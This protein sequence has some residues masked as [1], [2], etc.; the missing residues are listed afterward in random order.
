[1]SSG[2][3]RPTRVIAFAYKHG[4]SLH[5]KRTLAHFLKRTLAHFLKRAFVHFLERAFVLAFEFA[6]TLKLIPFFFFDSNLGLKLLLVLKLMLAFL[7]L[8]VALKRTTPTR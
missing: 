4:R 8:I 5:F 2:H 7:K 1:M 6:F 3:H